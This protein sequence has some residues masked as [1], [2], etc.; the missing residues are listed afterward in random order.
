M[1]IVEFEN[2]NDE[3]LILTVSPWGDEHTIPPLARVGILYTLKD[4]EE[5]RCYTSVSDNRFDF[6]C[7]ADSYEIEIIHPSP[8]GLLSWAMCVQGG[9]C[10]GIVN[11][12]PTTVDDLLPSTGTVSAL[13]FA[14]LAIRADG[15][16]D[17]D[18]YP[19]RHLDWI[20]AKFVEYLGADCVPVEDLK[21]NLTSAF[22]KGA[23]D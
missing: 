10:G 20:Q 7:N 14:R 23:S 3:D 11:D 6:W 21:F 16:P 9:W 17:N 2:H 8:Y 13:E 19:Q 1:P 5:D 15:W 18:P 12:Q 4:G 22:E